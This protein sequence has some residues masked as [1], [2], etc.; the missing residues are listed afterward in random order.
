VCN[1]AVSVVSTQESLLVKQ[2][3]NSSGNNN[4]AEA[5]DGKMI[6]G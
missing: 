5:T 2:H 6:L 1:A 4:G 3:V